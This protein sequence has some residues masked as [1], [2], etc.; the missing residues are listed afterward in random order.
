MIHL[1]FFYYPGR[2]LNF[3]TDSYSN[4]KGNSHTMSRTLVALQIKE[5]NVFRLYSGDSGR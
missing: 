2:G 5:K 4:L 1:A 3:A